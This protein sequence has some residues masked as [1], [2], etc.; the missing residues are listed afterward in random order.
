[1]LLE[2]EEGEWEKD[3]EEQI[4]SSALL[5]CQ[6]NRKIAPQED[7][8]LD[9]FWAKAQ[10]AMVPSDPRTSLQ[11]HVQEDLREDLREET[12]P[13]GKGSHRSK[14]HDVLLNWQTSQSQWQIP[15]L[16]HGNKETNVLPWM[17]KDNLEA[18]SGMKGR[19]SYGLNTG[20]KVKNGKDMIP[21]WEIPIDHV[22]STMKE[23]VVPAIRWC[24]ELR[25]W[26]SKRDIEG[27]ILEKNHWI[28]LTYKGQSVKHFIVLDFDHVPLDFDLTE[29]EKYAKD[30]LGANGCIINHKKDEQSFSISFH[31]DRFLQKNCIHAIVD[32]FFDIFMDKF[33]LLIDIGGSKGWQAKNIFMVEKLEEADNKKSKLSAS[34]RFWKNTTKHGVKEH[35]AWSF[36]ISS[37]AD[38]SLNG[39]WTS[40]AEVF[41]RNMVNACKLWSIVATEADK[42]EE[43]EEPAPTQVNSGALKN[44][45]TLILYK[46][47]CNLSRKQK[48]QNIR[49]RVKSFAKQGGRFLYANYNALK[50]LVNLVRQ[51][52]GTLQPSQHNQFILIH[53]NQE[54]QSP[55]YKNMSNPQTLAQEGDNAWERK[56]SSLSQWTKAQWAPYL[57]PKGQ[58]GQTPKQKRQSTRLTVARI[59]R[60][61]QFAY[62]EDV[63]GGD[64]RFKEAYRMLMGT[65]YFHFKYIQNILNDNSSSERSWT[66]YRKT[67]RNWDGCRE[68]IRN[69]LSKGTGDDW[70][71]RVLT[72][73]SNF[74]PADN[75]LTPSSS[76]PYSL[77]V[78]KG[79]SS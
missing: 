26:G 36:A 56:W 51:G 75:L 15:V 57:Q 35:K 34:V 9:D 73:L 14:K 72:M 4:Q 60:T 42:L 52:N 11:E 69:I 10:A 49:R 22:F 78:F 48:A 38:I 71:D 45:Q 61:F 2:L 62:E 43:K 21:F 40:H 24:T 59:L 27:N 50:D 65:A 18:I 54:K 13:K 44:E 58:K 63:K 25:R 19:V 29:V 55:E 3:N 64:P 1:M 46:N 16:L 53:E 74:E 68:E 33:G 66:R 39:N 67:I 7:D 32:C 30:V 41:H 6:D 47:S 23:A 76:T 12:L 79:L 8:N 20:L 37:D 77:S 31:F 28:P 5:K 70:L 17:E